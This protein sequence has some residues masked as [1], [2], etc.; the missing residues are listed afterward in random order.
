MPPALRALFWDYPGTRLSW[1]RD[2]DLII[3]RVLSAGSWDTIQW[4][5]R[6]VGDDSLRDWIERRAGAGLSPRQLRFWELVLGIPRQ[7][8]DAWLA[9]PDRAAWDGRRRR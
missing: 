8:V 7:Q 5:R 2:R 4:L 3:G 9:A 1:A 6:Q